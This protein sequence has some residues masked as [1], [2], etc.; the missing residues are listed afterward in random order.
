MFVSIAVI[1][2]VI[3]VVIGGAFLYMAYLSGTP[4][5]QETP[6][7]VPPTVVPATSVPTPLPT[8]PPP[9]T[10]SSPPTPAPTPAVP[11]TGVWVK[12]KYSGGWA[13]SYGVPGGLQQVTG[14]GDQYYQVPAGDGIVQVSFQKIEGS[15]N[16]LVVEVYKDGVLIRSGRT[17]VPKGTV[18]FQVDLKS[19]TPTVSPTAKQTTV[20]VTATQTTVNATATQT[21]RP[22]RAP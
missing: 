5:R 12:V 17:T 8:T 22:T 3:L 11:S 14:N 15:G 1:V 18:E 20:N 16:A 6:A 7:T 4:S 9:V 10:T 2:I 19:V 13:G 21:Q